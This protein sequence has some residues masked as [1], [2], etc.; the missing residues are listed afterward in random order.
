VEWKV[1]TGQVCVTAVVITCVLKGVD[2]VLVYAA[3]G[4][5]LASIGYPFATSKPISL[6][7]A[8]LRA[9]YSK[10]WINSLQMYAHKPL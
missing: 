3:L 2:H 6:T 7:I 1:I 4:G 10:G 9:R 8:S 5:L